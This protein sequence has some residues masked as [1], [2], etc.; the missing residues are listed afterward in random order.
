MSIE[1]EIERLSKIIQD[2]QE[3]FLKEAFHKTPS[4]HQRTIHYAVVLYY[5]ERAKLYEE[6]GNYKNA[7]DGYSMAIA[8]SRHPL[9]EQDEGCKRMVAECYVRLGFLKW[10]LGEEVDAFENFNEAVEIDPDTPVFFVLLKEHPED[11]A[12]RM[13]DTLYPMSKDEFIIFNDEMLSAIKSNPKTALNVLVSWQAAHSFKQSINI[14]VLELVILF[15]VRHE[16]ES[17][18]WNEIAQKLLDEN[19]TAYTLFRR[20]AEEKHPL[21]LFGLGFRYSHNNEILE[22]LLAYKE[23]TKQFPEFERLGRRKIRQVLTLAPRAIEEHIKKKEL[24][25]AAAI[26]R[27]LHDYKTAAECYEF[28]AKGLE[29]DDEN[30][31]Q[32]TQ[33][34]HYDEQEYGP[35]TGQ[36]VIRRYLPGAVNAAKF[37]RMAAK[38]YEK[39]GNSVQ[40]AIC[41]QSSR[42]L[43]PQNEQGMPEVINMSI[44]ISYS[45]KDEVIARHIAD[46]LQN[47][48]LACWL[49]KKDILVG[50]PILDRIREG[51]AR[52]SGY[53]L[54]LLSK[55]S[56]ASEWCKLELRMAYDKEIQR[57]R[58]VV[59]PI[60][61][62]EVDLPEEVKVKK[63]YQLNT[64]SKKS[65]VTLIE[66]IKSLI[67]RQENKD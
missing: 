24:N 30:I 28:L 64:R 10:R 52:E 17:H 32:S 36:H 21:G 66:E 4:D 13:L 25:T 51:I 42:R 14:D 54:I 16:I 37:Y 61:I 60:R 67:T 59:L 26:A 7:I 49:D 43:E 41:W 56:V 46:S 2:C 63:Y 62:D 38:C 23:F 6:Q 34:I 50:E 8:E 31:E 57:K 65:L 33:L 11:L 18:I 47:A 39:A 45:S 3:A 58:I 44:F 1:D 5:C 48:G 53:T 55:N 22:A 40:A 35:Y 12:A 29:N 27:R 15:E 9:L 19:I 20:L